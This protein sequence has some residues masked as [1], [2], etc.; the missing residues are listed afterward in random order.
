MKLIS[1]T[2]KVLELNNT[3]P[4][5]SQELHEVD[6]FYLECEVLEKI[7]DYANFLNQSLTLGMFIACDEDGNVLEEPEFNEPNNENEI[8]DYDELRYQYQQA[9]DKVLFEGFEICNRTSNIDCV[10]CKDDHISL[11][12]LKGKTV[13]YLINRD[14]TLTPNAIKQVKL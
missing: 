14:I 6:Y 8:G 13:E 5:P 3:R 11:K 1:M 10:V 9:K 7:C 2:D 12:L 4:T